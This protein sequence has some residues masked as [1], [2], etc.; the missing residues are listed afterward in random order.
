MKLI[1]IDMVRRMIPKFLKNFWYNYIGK[2]QFTPNEKDV[3][4]AKNLASRLKGKTNSETL[5]NIL[6]WQNENIF[7]WEERWVLFL[8]FI[9]STILFLFLISFFKISQPI[10]LG[11]AFLVVLSLI[12]NLSML[13]I[14]GYLTY[15]TMIFIAIFLIYPFKFTPFTLIFSI[16]FGWF[17]AIFLQLFIKY[18]SLKRWAT[19]FKVSDTFL[20]SLP[21][22]KILKYKLS[23]CRDYAKLTAALLLNLFPKN[24]IF[25]FTFVGHVAT[26]IELNGKTYILDQ[27]LPIVN[28]QTWLNS[29][30]KDKAT[31]LELKRNRNKFEVS[32]FGE[33]IRQEKMKLETPKQLVKVLEKAIKEGE[34]EVIYVLKDQAKIYD[35]N[36][37][38]IIESLLRY[39]TS[40]LQKEFTGNFSKIKRLNIT[41][42]G[43]D[44]MLRISLR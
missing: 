26:G 28:E 14:L 43:N 20:L 21:V 36:D 29:W 9:I 25:F 10:I 40:L 13:A 31:K 37:E 16:F 42:K 22:E 3:K 24:R 32:Y 35:T 7:A 19:E 27:K 8:N 34:K 39:Y 6:E 30:N 5:N 11:F 1:S 18:N 17:I 4:N 38:I 23:V 12:A 44:L 2:K 33:I 15:I 41:K